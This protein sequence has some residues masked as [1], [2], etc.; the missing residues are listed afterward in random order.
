MRVFVA[1]SVAR[2]K[3]DVDGT[4]WE[5]VKKRREVAWEAEAA[6]WRALKTGGSGLRRRRPRHFW[7][8][9]RIPPSKRF[10]Q[11]IVEHPGAGLQEQMGTALGPLHLLAL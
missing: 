6:G 9:L 11:L 2:K 3:R 7:P 5:L 10:L 4:V 1:R 8:K